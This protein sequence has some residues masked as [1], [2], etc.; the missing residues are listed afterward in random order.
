M[1]AYHDKTETTIKSMNDHI[2]SMIATIIDT[3]V[4][5]NKQDKKTTELSLKL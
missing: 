3:S 5:A 2:A 4:K 1:K